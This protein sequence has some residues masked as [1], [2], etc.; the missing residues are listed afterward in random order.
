LFAASFFEW[1]PIGLPSSITTIASKRASGPILEAFLAGVFANLAGH[2]LLRAVRRNSRGLRIWRAGPSEIFC[3]LPVSRHRKWRCP[4]GWPRC[5]SWLRSLASTSG[6]VD[7]CCAKVSR[8]LA[9]GDG[10]LADLRAVE[11]SGCVGW[12]R[13]RP[14][15]LAWPC[16]GYRASISCRGQ[17]PNCRPCVA[18]IRMDYRRPG[19]HASRLQFCP[20]VASVF[21]ALGGGGS[22]RRSIWTQLPGLVANGNTVLVDCHLPHG[23]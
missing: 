1:L 14:F 18:Q 5:V 11:H 12:R 4:I 9:V 16:L 3:N 10:G 2:A 7:A 19:Y 6:P 15:L 23:V 8:H 22:G 21:A 13:S 20:P 17:R